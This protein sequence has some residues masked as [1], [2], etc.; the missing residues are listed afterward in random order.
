MTDHDVPV[1]AFWVPDYND[2]TKRSA[3]FLKLDTGHSICVRAVGYWV[4]GETRK[5]LGFRARVVNCRVVR[6]GK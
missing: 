1:G 5:P 2:S 3:V 6:V 4:L